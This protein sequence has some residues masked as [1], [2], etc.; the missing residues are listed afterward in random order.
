MTQ[1]FNKSKGNIVPKFNGYANFPASDDGAIIYD[2]ITERYVVKRNGKWTWLQEFYEYV[3]YNNS[4]NDFVLTLSCGGGNLEMSPNKQILATIDLNIKGNLSAELVEK[5]TLDISTDNT[6]LTV[7]NVFEDVF[8]SS[9]DISVSFSGNGL[10]LVV[11]VNR[12]GNNET[13]NA[14]ANLVYVEG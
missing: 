9:N 10:E 4:T 6:T 5:A 8:A 1:Y 12:N 13:I 7:N 14:V 2:T 3:T 11:T